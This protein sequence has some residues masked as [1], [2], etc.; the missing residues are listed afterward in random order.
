[1]VVLWE[2]EAHFVKSRFPFIATEA[3]KT[4]GAGAEGAFFR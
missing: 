4:K 2:I 1:M 3:R